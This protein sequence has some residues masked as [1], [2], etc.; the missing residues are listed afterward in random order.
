MRG[1]TSILAGV[2]CASA[3]LTPTAHADPGAAVDAA[4]RSLASPT[5][6]VVGGNDWGCRSEREPVVVVHGSAGDGGRAM[7]VPPIPAQLAYATLTP[8]LRAKGYCV[9]GADLNNAKSLYHRE[10][11][12]DDPQRLLDT[13]GSAGAPTQLDVFVTGVLRA[14]GAERVDLIGHSLGAPVARSY[15]RGDGNP[16]TVDDLVSLGGSNL[17]LDDTWEHAPDLVGENPP[18]SVREIFGGDGGAFLA[19]LNGPD[20][21]RETYADVDYTA[22]GL[23]NEALIARPFLSPAGPNVVNFFL[24]PRVMQYDGQQ[25][26]VFAERAYLRSGEYDVRPVC[27]LWLDDGGARHTVW[28]ADPMAQ[29]LILRALAQDGPAPRTFDPC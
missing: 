19:W 10:P 15:L 23:N 29:R 11:P 26:D 4:A 7:D 22:L 9:F 24:G 2:L 12:Y 14:T 8:L 18:Q 5:L 3:A 6:T 20:N 17:H 28:A 27:P 1:I 16:A 13:I 25:Y 21:D